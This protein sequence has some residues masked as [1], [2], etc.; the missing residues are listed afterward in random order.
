[1][2]IDVFGVL[3]WAVAAAIVLLIAVYLPGKAFG[4]TA[5]VSWTA[6][7]EREDGT[8]LS[9]GEI[10][11]YDMEWGL[12]AGD[13]QLESLGPVLAH[14]VTL[15]EP[16]FGEWCFSV[17]TRD[18]DG[19]LSAFAGPVTKVIKAPPK[20]PEL[21]TVV[22]IAY[23]AKIHPVQGLV[24]GRAV[25]WVPLG[26]ACRGDENGLPFVGPDLYAIDPGAVA[27]TKQPK[28]ELILARC[29]GG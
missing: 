9:A 12:C 18:T 19:L 29:A 21:Q 3:K 14:T 20:P 27:Y 25:G 17:R 5:E 26:T 10:G 23:E 22:T 1:M 13:K 28:S 16:S 4:A 8:A 7:T 2:K 6:P 24:A 11:G 15:P